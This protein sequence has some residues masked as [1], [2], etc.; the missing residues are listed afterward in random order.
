MTIKQKQ[1]GD[2]IIVTFRVTDNEGVVINHTSHF[3]NIDE[4]EN[5]WDLLLDKPSTKGVTASSLDK[6]FHDRMSIP[7]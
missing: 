3:A 6:R 5:E 2:R 1:A 7:L 4:I